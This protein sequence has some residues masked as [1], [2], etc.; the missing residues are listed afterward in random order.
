MCGDAPYKGFHKTVGADDQKNYA[1]AK[2]A[3]G[4]LKA[5]PAQIPN[6]LPAPFVVGPA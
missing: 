6:K 4:Q 1:A 3:L 2:R 5:D